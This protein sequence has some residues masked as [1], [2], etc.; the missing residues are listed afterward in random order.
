MKTEPVF[1]RQQPRAP[2]A[3]RPTPGFT[4]IELLVVI[5]IIA[6]LAAM[7]LPALSS[8][9]E[10]ALRVKCVSNLRQIGIGALLYASDNGD[11][12]PQR[13]WPSGQN[14]WQTYEA[15]RVNAGSS[16]LTRGPYNLG[17]LFFT[18]AIPNPEVF[19]CPSASKVSPT[20][21]YAYYS[22][23]P[24]VWPST[25]AASG[26][27]NIR[28]SYNYYPQPRDLERYQ[29]YELPVLAYAGFV[30]SLGNKLTEPVALK[31]TQADPNRTMS[32]DLL[33]SL[34]TVPHRTGVAKAG[35]NALFADSHI[36]FQT[37]R[38]NPQAFSTGA[39][40]RARTGRI[41]AQFPARLV[42]FSALSASGQKPNR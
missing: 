40:G 31:V 6:I 15:C 28:S 21:G 16:S 11:S 17:L 24:N 18:K 27:D 14:P 19:Y 39:L 4:L 25:P 30:D 13:H 38:A 8:A 33:H 12:L 2:A 10:R 35:L 41:T 22:T 20:W 9:K 37:V 23:A 5:A 7:L 36:R 42:F 34:D 32:T 29:G 1:Q 26:D 3:L